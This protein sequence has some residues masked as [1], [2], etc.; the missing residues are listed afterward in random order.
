MARLSP[1]GNIVTGAVSRVS[2]GFLLNPITIVKARFESSH[3]AR[4]AYPTITASLKSIYRE[5]GFPGFFRG[6]S[7][8]AMRDAPYA[9]LY[10]A[11]YERSKV[12][13]SELAA[14]LQ[15]VPSLREATGHLH[16]VSASSV[17]A[18]TVATL[19]THPF[20]IVKTR[21]QTTPVEML[22]GAKPSFMSTV[23]HIYKTNGIGAF[24]DGVWLRCTR[25]G[26]SSAIAWSI[27]EIGN[28]WAT[29]SMYSK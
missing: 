14:H 29:E 2:I 26:A 18:A 7:A 11:V 25:K 6:F 22:H 4:D 13:L 3:Y 5:S 17:I 1:A 12:L 10:L 8:T 24:A 20:D 27:F 19:L 15:S 16:V 23:R 21:M 9:G 28:R